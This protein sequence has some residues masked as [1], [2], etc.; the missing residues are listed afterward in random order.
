MNQPL[1]VTC[2]QYYVA[3]CSTPE[4]VLNRKFKV[5]NT[6]GFAKAKGRLGIS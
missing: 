5:G 4:N 3:S 1:Y 6:L 2:E